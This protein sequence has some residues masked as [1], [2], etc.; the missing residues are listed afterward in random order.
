MV[1]LEGRLWALCVSLT[2]LRYRLNRR[3]MLRHHEFVPYSST[4]VARRPEK[5]CPYML[6]TRDRTFPVPKKVKQFHDHNEYVSE[7]FDLVFKYVW[8]Y[9][10]G[11]NRCYLLSAKIKS[12][13]NQLVMF[14]CAI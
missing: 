4:A 5:R 3:G 14:L 7:N 11:K 13:R 9:R 8:M 1:I 10:K 2:F 12:K 6:Y